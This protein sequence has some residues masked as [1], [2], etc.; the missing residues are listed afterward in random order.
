MTRTEA[1]EILRQHNRWR[2]GET[3]HQQH[4]PSEVGEAID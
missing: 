1:A 2:R 3:D 4:N